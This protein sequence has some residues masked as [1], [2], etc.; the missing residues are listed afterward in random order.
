MPGTDIDP[1]IASIH[2]AGRWSL[3]AEGSMRPLLTLRHGD[4]RVVSFQGGE[5]LTDD[6]DE[7]AE[8]EAYRLLVVYGAM[9][10]VT[11]A[12]L[13]T[14]GRFLPPPQGEGELPAPY[15]VLMTLAGWRTADGEII[16][17]A[18]RSPVTADRAAG[19]VTTAEP[20]LMPDRPGDDFG[21]LD[22]LLADETAY[23]AIL[24]QLGPGAFE[25][26]RAMAERFMAALAIPASALN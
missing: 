20:I 25:D 19:R 22:G 18:L 1:L 15:D 16:R 17:C 7:L 13:V 9:H 12:A 5:L 3:E 26:V 11:H 14:V 2:A 24:G 4:G 23:E 8:S 21:P 6:D 10:K